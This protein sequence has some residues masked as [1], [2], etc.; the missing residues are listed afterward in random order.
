MAYFNENVFFIYCIKTF[1]AV[2]ERLWSYLQR[3]VNPL[4]FSV[5]A[6]RVC[7]F[8]FV[9]SLSLISLLSL[10]VSCLFADWLICSAQA[11]IYNLEF[12]TGA[13]SQRLSQILSPPAPRSGESD[14]LIIILF[15]RWRHVANALLAFRATTIS[16]VPGGG[17]RQMQQNKVLII[18]SQNV[19]FL[20]N[21]RRIKIIDTFRDINLNLHVSQID[22]LKTRLSSALHPVGRD[23][24]LIKSGRSLSG[25]AGLLT[26]FFCLAPST[27]EK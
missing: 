2:D 18:S 12:C 24:H 17:S 21:I 9:W 15:D 22:W 25:Q 6:P 4:A 23:P 3:H 1:P 7:L 27:T 19:F 14:L 11:N 26:T 5:Q 10:I 16:M 8:T 20:V 13:K